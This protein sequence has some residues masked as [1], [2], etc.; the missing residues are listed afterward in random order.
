MPHQVL[1]TPMMKTW[2]CRNRWEPSGVPFW[3]PTIVSLMCQCGYVG[4]LHRNITLR[5]RNWKRDFTGCFDLFWWPWHP[6]RVDAACVARCGMLRALLE[7]TGCCCRESIFAVSPRWLPWSSMLVPVGY[8]TKHNFL[9]SVL[10]ETMD[11][12]IEFFGNERIIATRAISMINCW[13]STVMTYNVEI[14]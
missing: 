9:A 12:P 10:Y 5:K 13:S 7:A 8:H 6:P 1:I 2:A 14:L 4:H 3:W 11:R